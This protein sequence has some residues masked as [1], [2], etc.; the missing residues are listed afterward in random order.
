MSRLKNGKRPVHPG[1]ILVQEYLR[2]SSISVREAAAALGIPYET[3]L[4][5]ACGQLPITADLAALLERTFAGEAHGWLELQAA[6]DRRMAELAE[7]RLGRSNAPTWASLNA[8]TR[9]MVL[10]VLGAE[11]LAAEWIAAPAAGLN[12]QRPIDLLGTSEGTDAVSTYLR[13]LMHGVYC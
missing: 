6:F 2:P 7:P 1:E 3:L 11:D 13:R 12:W 5:V 8:A 4:K 9:Q 10:E